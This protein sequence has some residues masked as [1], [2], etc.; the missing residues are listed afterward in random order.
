[1]SCR[2]FSNCVTAS[3]KPSGA[4]GPDAMTNALRRIN[5]PGLAVMVL[6]AGLWELYCRTFGSGFDSIASTAATVVAIK[7]LLLQGPL[8]EQLWHTMSVAIM[9]WILASVLGF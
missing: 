7:N 2:G 5:L 3:I 9:G 1:K 4:K 8:P 6:C